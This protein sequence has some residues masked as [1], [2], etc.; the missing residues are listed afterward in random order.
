[1]AKV[2]YENIMQDWDAHIP[3]MGTKI[4]DFY[5]SLIEAWNE[6]QTGL[7][8]DWENV[9]GLFGKKKRMMK[10]KWDRFCCYIGS[11]AFGTDL[12]CT[13]QLYDPKF[14]AGGKDN[15]LVGLFKSDFNEI[16]E[17]R[18]F[19]AVCLDCAQKAVD[20]ICEDNNLDKSKIKKQSSGALGPL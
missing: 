20:K 1:M 15:T 6:K 18:A 5:N 8:A 4:E 3:G 14:S 12:C 17:I 11:E 19:A 16:N 13:W 7:Q 10:I 9:G 2:K